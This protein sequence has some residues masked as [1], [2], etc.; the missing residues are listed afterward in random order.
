MYM[1][2]SDLEP[3]M[4]IDILTSRLYAIGI[5]MGLNART[6]REKSDY[7][8]MASETRIRIAVLTKSLARRE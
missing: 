1:K 8:H 5:E 3:L 2:Y 4:E 6:K 7:D